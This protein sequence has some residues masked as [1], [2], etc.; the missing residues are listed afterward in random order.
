MHWARVVSPLC[1]FLL[2]GSSPAASDTEEDTIPKMA[3]I[4]MYGQPAIARDPV[5]KQA[6]EAFVRST[7]EQFENDRRA[8]CL[9]MW[10]AAERHLSENRPGAAMA[11][12]NQAWL[13]DPR[14]FHPHW[15]MGRVLM[16]KGELMAAIFHLERARELGAG[17]PPNVAMLADLATGYALAS[18]GGG[19]S[20]TMYAARADSQFTAC[21][22]A[23]SAYAGGWLAWAR[24]DYGASRFR[25]AWQKVARARSLGTLLPASFLAQLRAKLPEPEGDR[26]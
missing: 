5:L 8:A 15:G 19:A 10:T 7:L 11:R 23:D 26:R 16:R 20:A 17:S 12:Y 9:A 25:D 13:I 4:P 1:V 3:M 22:R 2:S 21:L 18:S 14:S 24:A 6:D